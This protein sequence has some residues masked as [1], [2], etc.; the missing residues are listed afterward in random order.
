VVDCTLAMT[1]TQSSGTKNGM[2]GDGIDWT[3]RNRLDSVTYIYTYM[4]AIHDS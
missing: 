4:A 2:M 1:R 3:S